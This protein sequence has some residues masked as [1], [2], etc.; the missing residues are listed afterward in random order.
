[1]SQAILNDL[2][3]VENEVDAENSIIQARLDSGFRPIWDRYF[4]V[5]NVTFDDFNYKSSGNVPN[6]FS[7]LGINMR[8]LANTK[9]FAKLEAFISSLSFKPSGI[10]INLVF[11]V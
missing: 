5:S 7:S 6:N 8:S 1:M 9:N 4:D 3:L 11:I 10:A 2:F